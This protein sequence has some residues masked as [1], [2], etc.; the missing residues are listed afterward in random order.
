M[1][2]VDG[3]LEEVPLRQQKYVELALQIAE[4]RHGWDST[5]TAAN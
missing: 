4:A 5:V 1:A 2:A 3:A